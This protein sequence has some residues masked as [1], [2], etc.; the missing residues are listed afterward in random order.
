MPHVRRVRLA[1]D[2]RFI[3]SETA[4]Y[5]ARPNAVPFSGEP[6]RLLIVTSFIFVFACAHSAAAQNDTAEPTFRTGVERVLVPVVIRDSTGKSVSGLQRQ[7]FRIYDEG[8][9][10]PI[11]DFSLNRRDLSGQRVNRSTSDSTAD[12][13]PAG[14]PQRFITYI[15]DDRH[16]SFQDLERARSAFED[17]LSGEVQPDTRAAVVA[18]SGQVFTAFTS[19]RAL[20]SEAA[21]RI[22]PGHTTHTGLACPEI[23]Y[24]MADL[25]VNRRDSSA[26]NAAYKQLI[27]CGP[28][29]P[30]PLGESIVKTEAARILRVESDQTVAALSVLERALERLSAVRGRREMV[31]LSSGFGLVRERAE[32]ERILARAVES[33]VVISA[34]NAHGVH[35]G[36]VDASNHLPSARYTAE[37]LRSR[38]DSIALM[39]EM[40]GGRYLANTNDVKGSLRVLT[41]EPEFVYILGFAPDV[42]AS[43]GVFRKL[44]VEVAG[45]KHVSVQAR[46]GYFAPKSLRTRGLSELIRSAMMAPEDVNDLSLIVGTQ[47]YAKDS[48]S[49]LRV[50]A[51]IGAAGLAFRRCE[52]QLCNELTVV[53]GLFDSNG[54]YMGEIT[55][56]ADL[57]FS[58]A[59]MD[60]FQKQGIQLGADFNVPPRAYTARVVVIDE[61]ARGIAAVALEVPAPPE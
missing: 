45:V 27:R 19:D 8:K 25:I 39:A 20:L 24:Y 54:G 57:R 40:T 48:Q 18:T 44:K 51:R 5:V 42:I 46:R 61:E 58:A 6:V 47:F 34:I 15:F 30:Q 23:S 53:Y 4:A 22:K 29:V 1:V 59:A 36:A 26:L 10:R 2:S 43:P 14:V 7:H 3:Y 41:E 17:H 35:S 9:L 37:S 13:R 49:T 55:R 21:R 38:S 11:T 16:I 33:R 52:N 31:V 32:Y 56:K 60:Q 28:P 12:Q 50:N